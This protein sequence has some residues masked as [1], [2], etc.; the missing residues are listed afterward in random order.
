MT[1]E[2]GI[3]TGAKQPKGGSPGEIEL[4][5]ILLLVGRLNYAWTNTESLLIH[6]IAGLAK[7][8]KDVAVVIFLTLS[9]TRAR[10]D[11][12]DRLA[13]M[14]GFPKDKRDEI[15]ALTSGLM[16]EGALRNKYN[17]CIYSFDPEGGR[18]Q[19]I[20]MRIHDRKD[21]IRV[22]KTETVNNAEVANIDACIS[23]LE[24]LN[25]KIWQTVQ[26]FGFPI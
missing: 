2:A 5:D 20:M 8:E 13:K 9:T 7:V 24:K 16:K 10:T 21:E 15:L 4:Q 22:G 23:R 1:D 17:H 18:I 12:V 14:P 3:G 26:K 6:L 19:T 11:L 25:T